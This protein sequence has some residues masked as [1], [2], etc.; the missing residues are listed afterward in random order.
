M[1]LQNPK[2]LRFD[3]SFP[4]FFLG[5][6][7]LDLY[8]SDCKNKLGFVT[9]RFNLR[10]FFFHDHFLPRLAVL[11]PCFIRRDYFQLSVCRLIFIL[12]FIP[13]TM[14]FGFAVGILGMFSLY[15]L[16]LPGRWRF[17]SNTN[18]LSWIFSP[19]LPFSAVTFSRIFR[20]YF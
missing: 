4:A 8:F 1:V 20:K 6:F 18:C 13:L 5:D 19:K 10:E 7:G 9:D 16:P 14:F 2:I 11:C 3:T 17:C 15:Y 12:P